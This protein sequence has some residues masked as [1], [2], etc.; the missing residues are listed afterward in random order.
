VRISILLGQA[1]KRDR[2]AEALAYVYREALGEA[3]G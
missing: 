3:V 1:L 2:H